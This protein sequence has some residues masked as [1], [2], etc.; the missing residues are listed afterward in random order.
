VKPTNYKSADRI[1]DSELILNDDGSVYH[2]Q[3]HG[4]QIADTV[5][6]VGDPDRVE[7]ISSRFDTIEFTKRVREFCTHT[8]SFNGKRITVVSSGIGVDN[9]DI[10]INELHAAINV[11]PITRQVRDEIRKLDI[12]RLGTCGTMQSDIPVG[13]YVSSAFA[14]GTDGVPWHYNAEM[15]QEEERLA[16]AFHLHCNWPKRFAYPYCSAGTTELLELFDFAQSGI[17][18]TANGF[19]APQQRQVNIELSHPELLGLYKTFTHSGFRMINFE[20]ECAGIYAL[21]TMLGHKCVTVCAILANRAL[22]E[23]SD[24]PS[25]VVDKLID[26]I[27]SRLTR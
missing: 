6:I 9:I 18:L 20:M 16:E 4:H 14:I 3:L 5:I 10:L 25:G 21:S 22:G 13:S 15:T 8:G 17:T 23:F 11:D 19:Y 27:M 7:T 12:V 26:L 2:L 1:S 24:D